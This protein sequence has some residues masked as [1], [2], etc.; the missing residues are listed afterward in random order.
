MI[1][2]FLYFHTSYK[3]KDIAIWYSGKR[4]KRV[5][6]LDIFRDPCLHKLERK[7]EDVFNLFNSRLSRFFP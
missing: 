3:S 1:E 6:T 7:E 2:D 5:E 4:C